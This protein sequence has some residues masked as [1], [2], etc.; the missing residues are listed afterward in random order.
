MLTECWNCV[1]IKFN[2]FQTT[3]LL[4]KNS[5]TSI[6]MVKSD[7]RN[8]QKL[9]MVPTNIYYMDRPGHIPFRIQLIFIFYFLFIFFPSS[10]FCL[11]KPV[12]LQ[13]YQMIINYVKQKQQQNKNYFL[14]WQI[15]LN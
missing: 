15:K 5:K 3:N 1:E 9:F 10:K 6:N 13:A 4:N 7:F 8:Y 11:N 12:R 2:K 14:K